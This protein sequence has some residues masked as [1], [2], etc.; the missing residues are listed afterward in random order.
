MLEYCARSELHPPRRIG[1]AERASEVVSYG[2]ERNEPE[3]R[4]PLQGE[5]LAAL[6]P[7]LKT[8]AVL[9]SHFTAIKTRLL[10]PTLN[11]EEH[12]CACGLCDLRWI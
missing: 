6:A 1:D 3:N 2:K 4:S 11:P 8:W 10:H 9:S 7:G 5:F 12:F